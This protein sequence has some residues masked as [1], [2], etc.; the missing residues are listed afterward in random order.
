MR[1]I[2]LLEVEIP[3]NEFDVKEVSFVTG[4][5]SRTP[6]KYSRTSFFLCFPPCDVMLADFQFALNHYIARDRKLR[7][8]PLDSI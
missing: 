6:G 5:Y 7:E 2:F 8:I 3:F 4:K 1:T